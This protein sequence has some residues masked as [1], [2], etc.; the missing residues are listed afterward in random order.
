VLGVTRK[1]WRYPETE[2]KKK[3]KTSGRKECTVTLRK[4][5]HAK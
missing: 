4:L 5:Q 1:T 2:E 3:K